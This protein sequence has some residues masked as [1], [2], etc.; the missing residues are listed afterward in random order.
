[1]LKTIV[2]NC[3]FGILI[4]DHQNRVYDVNIAGAKLLEYA[5][6]EM[7]GNTLDLYI[8]HPKETVGFTK[9]GELKKLQFQFDTF[10]N[11]YGY[12][13]FHD[14]VEFAST[15]LL[16]NA[17]TKEQFYLAITKLQTDYSLLFIDLDKF[18]PVNDTHGHVTGDFVLQTIGKRIQ[19]IIRGTDLFCRY[20][21]DEFIIVVAGDL[22]A[23]E[24]VSEKIQNL[25]KEPIRT[26]EYTINISCSIGIALSVE[27][28]NINQLIHIAD[29][30]MYREKERI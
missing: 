3:P 9:S 24:A 30:R 19:N 16:T 6:S 22:N 27:A 12:V 13:I 28:T 17:L 25:I 29:T 7:I 4:V 5:P 15:D 2:E 21:G 23:A 1:M 18:K 10:E 8:G 20:G 26:R 14:P 11:D